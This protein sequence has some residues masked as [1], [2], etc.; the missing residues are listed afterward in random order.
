MVAI[1]GRPVELYTL[2]DDYDVKDIKSYSIG[3]DV[4]VGS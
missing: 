2:A 3:S 1:T 4:A